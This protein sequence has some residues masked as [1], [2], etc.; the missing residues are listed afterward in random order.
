MS[1]MGTLSEDWEVFAILCLLY[2]QI[3]AVGHT[4]SQIHLN[5]KCFEFLS[6]NIKCNNVD[7][8]I[9]TKNLFK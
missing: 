4:F 2:K 9:G 6:N 7:I 5:E 3:H 1:E 8:H